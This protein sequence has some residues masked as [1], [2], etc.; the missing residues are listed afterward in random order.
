MVH[1]VN[2]PGNKAGRHTSG[3]PYATPPEASTVVGPLW[4]NMVQDEL[5]AMLTA[6]GISP[7][8]SNN[9]Q[10][11]LA[12]VSLIGSAIDEELG[13]TITFP[14]SQAYT[15]GT[16]YHVATAIFGVP[17]TTVAI[18]EQVTFDLAGTFAVPK[19]LAEAMLFGDRLY[20]DPAALE[21]TLDGTGGRYF[22]GICVAS[23]GSGT[24]TTSL[25][26]WSNHALPPI[27]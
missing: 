8:V 1:L 10:L 24:A 5:L 25:R 12:V 18:G 15:A 14:A 23:S 6:A 27:P 20:W 13:R 21:V 9:G 19:A 26:M 11:L 7:D 4:L 2:T 16:P 22:V 3:N 17:R